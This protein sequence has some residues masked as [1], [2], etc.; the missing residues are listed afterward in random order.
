MRWVQVRDWSIGPNRTANL[1]QFGGP[2]MRAEGRDHPR[3]EATVASAMAH[4]VIH[5]NK[6]AQCSG[7]GLQAREHS[8]HWFIVNTKKLET[9][10]RTISAG[11]PYT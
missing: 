8:E 4:T 7:M 2:E 9:G 10:L 6:H 1:F 3:D 5:P 11:I